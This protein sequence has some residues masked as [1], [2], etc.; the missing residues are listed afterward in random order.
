MSKKDQ[1]PKHIAIV[2]DGNGRWANKRFLPRAAGHREG[3]KAAKNI[4]EASGK[5]GVKILTLFAFSSE[6]WNRPKAEVSAL[7]NIF[8]SSL[9]NEIQ[10]LNKNGVKLNFIG[11][12]DQFDKKLVAKIKE[13]IALTQNNSDF[14][15]NI[16]ANYGG[17]WDI[18]KACREICRNVQNNNISIQDINEEVFSQAISTYPLPEPDLFIRTA[19][20][21]R[22][23]NFLLWQLAY[24]ELYFTDTLWPDFDEKQLLMALSS[25]SQRKRKFGLTQDQVDGKASA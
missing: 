1:I 11:D 18:V 13:S 21:E 6:N 4:I 7:M 9:E 15:L 25:Y 23:S 5:S 10:T 19:G 3:V 14:V 17:R 8:V 24:T 2:M 12:Q 20:E 22:I 16:A